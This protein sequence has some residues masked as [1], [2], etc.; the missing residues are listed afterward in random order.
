MAILYLMKRTWRELRA[1]SHRLY[2]QALETLIC[3]KG[4]TDLGARG[5]HRQRHAFKGGLPIR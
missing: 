1:V 2:Q 5:R 3:A 4:S